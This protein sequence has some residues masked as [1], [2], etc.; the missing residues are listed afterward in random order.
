M[1]RPRPMLL[2][3][4]DLMRR[5]LD[6]TGVNEPLPE[7]I[8]YMRALL[9]LHESL[10]SHEQA[11]P[12]LVPGFVI[13]RQDGGHVVY[14]WYHELLSSDGAKV[15]LPEEVSWHYIRWRA[16][17]AARAWAKQ[18]RSA[19]ARIAAELADEKPLSTSENSAPLP[20][21]NKSDKPK[22]CLGCADTKSFTDIKNI[23][24]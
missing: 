14:G 9:A 15:R 11:V 4:L 16:K 6:R 7:Q 2:A 19:S 23:G 3:V 13:R 5:E 24:A 21:G 18:A 22:P 1:S 12:L 20:V 10:C 17:L 8:D